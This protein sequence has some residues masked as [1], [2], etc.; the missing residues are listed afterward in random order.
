MKT[1]KCRLTLGGRPERDYLQAMRYLIVLFGLLVATPASAG[2]TIESFMPS[3]NAAL[4]NPSDPQAA[5][6]IF[7]VGGMSDVFTSNMLNWPVC[8]PAGTTTADVVRNFVEWANHNTD[9]WQEDVYRGVM[10]SLTER[11]GC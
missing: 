2:Y 3:C 8:A 10:A 6:C 4:R 9:V 5:P 1:H 7:Y 11:Y